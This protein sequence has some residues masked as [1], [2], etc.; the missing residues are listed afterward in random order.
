V[1]AVGESEIK[2]RIVQVCKRLWDRN[3]LASA[4]GN[5]SYRIDDETILITPSGLAKAFMDP[6]QMAVMNLK[7][8]V[9]HGTPS[10]E[11]AMH[12]QVYQSCPEA[13][14]VVHA[15][16]PHAIA[17]SIAKPDLQELPSTSVSEVI[18]ACG[19]I[20]LVPYATPTTNAMAANLLPF[21][22]QHR[23]MILSR[24]GGLS[25]GESLDEA[26]GGMERLEHSSEILWLAQ[27]MGELTGL[28]PAEVARL[29]EM[30]SQIGPRTF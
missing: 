30:R 19:S 10:G 28:P 27:S 3:M 20:P 14:A 23:L 6:E 9:L 17:W 29:R 22:P 2:R 24:H 16:P 5:V 11:R 12:L 4:D 25:W 13:K 1:I 15:H 8:E 7:G 18:L 21:L 26:V